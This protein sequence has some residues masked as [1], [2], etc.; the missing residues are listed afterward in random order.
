MENRASRVGASAVCLAAGLMAPAAHADLMQYQGMGTYQITKYTA[1]Y[2]VFEFTQPVVSQIGGF[3]FTGFS[4]TA[5]QT[6]SVPPELPDD[7]VGTGVLVGAT[8]ADTLTVDFHG[9][10]FGFGPGTASVAASV[11][12]SGGTGAYAGVFGLGD[13]SG[14][15]IYGTG[16]TGDLG[17]TLQGDLPVPTPGAM[18][19]LGLAGLVAA[20]RRRM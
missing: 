7:V 1:T 5:T 11:T 4:G 14:W 6:F 16:L 9:L 8:P 15:V 19:L 20:R 13:L 18:A 12:F 3:G 10:G 17:V 2:V